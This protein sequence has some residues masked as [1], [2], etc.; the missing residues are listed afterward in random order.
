MQTRQPDPIIAEVRAIRRAY[1]A[2]FDYDVEAIFK[3]L[4]ARQ[5][6]SGREYVRLPAKT[7]RA[8]YRNR[9]PQL[10]DL[11]PRF[12]GEPSRVHVRNALGAT[13]R[14]KD[15]GTAFWSEGAPQLEKWR[16]E[17][18]ELMKFI[19]QSLGERRH[20]DKQDLSTALREFVQMFEHSQ[21]RLD[22]LLQSG[23]SEEDRQRILRWCD[24]VYRLSTYALIAFWIDD[25]TEHVSTRISMRVDRTTGDVT[26]QSMET[27]VTKK[28]AVPKKYKKATER[29]Q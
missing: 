19:G 21:W 14:L 20:L 25:K 27:E 18:D 3:D 29:F 22:Q 24:L 7:G 6:A 1:A 5:E 10:L 13:G 26:E 23:P 28:M 2:R 9:R 11:V 8:R 15:D 4:R 16:Y 12:E 17:C